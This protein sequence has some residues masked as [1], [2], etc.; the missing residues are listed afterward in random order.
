[1]GVEL[2]RVLGTLLGMVALALVA[3]SLLGDATYRSSPRFDE[4]LPASAAA[5]LAVAAPDEALT[6]ARVAAP[7]GPR[8]LLVERV[9]DG[10]LTVWT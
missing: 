7:G 5:D 2:L 10:Q 1:M 4:P 8:L 6:F 9:R 3:L